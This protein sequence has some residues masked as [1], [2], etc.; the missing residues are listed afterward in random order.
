[1]A[2]SPSQV[3][4]AS[5]LTSPT[6]LPVSFFF[7]RTAKNG[8]VVPPVPRFRPDLGLHP[9]GELRPSW[10][11]GV[12]SGT[13]DEKNARK[14]ARETPTRRMAP[15]CRRERV[16]VVL[17][18]SSSAHRRLPRASSSARCKS[19]CRWT[20]SHAVRRVARPPIYRGLPRVWP[21]TFTHFSPIHSPPPP[22]EQWRATAPTTARP[23]TASAGAPC[24]SERP[25]ALRGGLPGVSQL[26]RA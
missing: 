1:V 16:V 10:P 22:G 15:T 8:P 21:A 5:P 7:I 17:I 25:A 20:S 14:T 11:S 4:R 19:C 23:T 18:A 2:D 12:R 26:P 6:R 13:P 9:S 24:T 3:L